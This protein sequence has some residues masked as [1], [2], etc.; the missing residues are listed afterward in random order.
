MDCNLKK[1]GL[2]FFRFDH[3]SNK[4]H[5]KLIMV[6][7]PFKNSLH[8]FPWSSKTIFMYKKMLLVLIKCEF[9]SQDIKTLV[10]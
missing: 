1:I 9:L 3:V 10:T 8:S 5:Y 7:S 2:L 4:N 6:C